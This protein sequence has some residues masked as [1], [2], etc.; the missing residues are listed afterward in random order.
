MIASCFFAAKILNLALIFKL[1]YPPFK[2][3]CRYIQENLDLRYSLR[4]VVFYV[5]IQRVYSLIYS[6]T[7]LFGNFLF[8]KCNL[9]TF[10]H[11]FKFWLYNVMFFIGCILSKI[12]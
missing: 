8:V 11:L 5:V 3:F 9:K 2:C 7:L 4:R 12:L 1:F 6:L 10:L